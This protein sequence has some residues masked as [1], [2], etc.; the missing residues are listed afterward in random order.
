MNIK[1]YDNGGESLDRFTIVYMER[2]AFGENAY[3]ARSM[4]DAPKHPCGVS[5]YAIVEDGTHLGKSIRFEE[6]PSEC[7]VIVKSDLKNGE[8][9]V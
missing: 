4:C 5:L 3:E 2:I 1:C 7:Q 8:D 9:Y 6:L